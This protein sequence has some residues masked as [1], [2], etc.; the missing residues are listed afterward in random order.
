MTVSEALSKM[1]AIVNDAREKL[2]GNGFIMSVETDFMDSML[3]VLPNENKAK[4]VTVSLIIGKEG[5]KEGEEYCISLGAVIL[6]NTV[7]EA[8][9]NSDIESYHKLVNDTIETL[10]G[11][12]NKDEGLD[13]L[14]K[15]ASDEYE[16]MMTER[17]EYQEKN[18]KISRIINAVFFGGMILLFIVMMIVKK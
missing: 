16:K 18:R 5:G 3:R 15:K 13:Y 7:Y 9:L 6:R 2:D 1:Q 14:T 4:Y 11:Y 17:R 10:A 8:R 12:D